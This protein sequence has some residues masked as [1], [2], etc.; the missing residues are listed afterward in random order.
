MDVRDPLTARPW[1]DPSTA[2]PWRDPVSLRL[3]LVAA[4]AAAVLLVLAGLVA[5]G[6]TRA[7]DLAVTI[8]FQS[9]ATPALD[10]LVNWHTLIGQAVTT[11]VIAGLLSLVLWRRGHRWSA[12]APLLLPVTALIELALK[13][14]LHHAGPP[15]E[16]VR[17]FMNPLGVR[18][19]A[20]SAFPS[21]QAAR[22]AF[23][24][25]VAIAM[26]PQRRLR[27]ALLAY[28]VFT[29][30]ARVYIGDHWISDV[31]GGA[32]LGVAVGA[33]AMIWIRSGGDHSASRSPSAAPRDGSRDR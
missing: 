25:L 3:W 28:L 30:F 14:S 32:A 7:A 23:L 16:Y 4:G 18:L 21:G 20:P 1:R 19:G 31:L 11:S 8:A 17:A 22:T 2:R 9:V 12:L 24:V 6:A 15:E 10:L 13:F 29:I 5:L 33:P 27:A 26:L